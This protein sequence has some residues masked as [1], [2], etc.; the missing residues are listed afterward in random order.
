M[1]EKVLSR[2][3]IL[4]ADDL[5]RESIEVPEWGGMI[6]VRTMTGTE[7]DAFESTLVEGEGMNRKQSLA[8]FRARL[9]AITA[10]DEKG[11]RLFSDDD[12]TRLGMKSSLAISRI[13]NVAQR[14]NG[15]GQEAENLIKN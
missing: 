10:T 13:F 11:V 8:N 2:D 12:A 1:I 15:I 7:R 3:S 6:Y 9:V 14:L 4:E 5:P